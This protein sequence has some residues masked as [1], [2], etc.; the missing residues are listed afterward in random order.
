MLKYI[1]YNIEIKNV[2]DT[3]QRNIINLIKLTSYRYNNLNTNDF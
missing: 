2:N 1:L 3:I